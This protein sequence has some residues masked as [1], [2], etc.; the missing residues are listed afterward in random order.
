MTIA[1]VTSRMSE[2]GVPPSNV[3]RH[4]SVNEEP[5]TI[6]SRFAGAD[7]AAGTLTKMRSS[8]DASLRLAPSRA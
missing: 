7:G 1:P 8:F 4:A 6:P 2:R 3:F 5:L